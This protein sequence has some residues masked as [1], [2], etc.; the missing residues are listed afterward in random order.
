MARQET[1][2]H[3]VPGAAFE[4]EK[5]RLREIARELWEDGE[6]YELVVA[7]VEIQGSCVVG[8][9]GED[10]RK[11][12]GDNSFECTAAESWGRKGLDIE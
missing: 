10:E 3:K 11:E 5:A 9:V 1:L 6:E 8:Q 2:A 12:V 7:G 4:R